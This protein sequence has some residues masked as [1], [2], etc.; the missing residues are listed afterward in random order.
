MPKT[1]EKLTDPIVLRLSKTAIRQLNE[2]TAEHLQIRA[3]IEIAI[4]MAWTMFKNQEA[5]H[6]QDKKLRE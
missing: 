3:R 6:I 5:W 4:N 2:I 1:K